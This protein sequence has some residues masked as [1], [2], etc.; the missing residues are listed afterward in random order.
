MYSFTG[1]T[2]PCSLPA[3]GTQL[4]TTSIPDHA[5]YE[6]FGTAPAIL[7]HAVSLAKDTASPALLDHSVI[8]P[9]IQLYLFTTALFSRI[10][11]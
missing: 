9:K 6:L 5:V 3:K 10:N 7:D 1:Y 4:H 8:L 2:G 11:T